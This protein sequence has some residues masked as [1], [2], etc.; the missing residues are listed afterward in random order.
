M[1]GLGLGLGLGLV[2]EMLMRCLIY[3]PDEMKQESLQRKPRSSSEG[4][5]ML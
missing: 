3:K 1:L 5:M 4:L 2:N